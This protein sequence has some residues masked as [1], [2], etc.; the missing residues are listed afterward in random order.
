MWHVSNDLD[1]NLSVHIEHRS[2]MRAD[3]LS[4]NT[5]FNTVMWSGVLDQL[6]RATLHDATKIERKWQ[7]NVMLVIDCCS[8][9]LFEQKLRFTVHIVNN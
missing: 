3:S 2:G 8:G 4:K 1:S 5:L 6:D 9:N 7:Q